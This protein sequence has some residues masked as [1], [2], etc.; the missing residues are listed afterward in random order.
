M[1]VFIFQMPHFSRTSPF[2]AW[3]KNIALD[4]A[5]VLYIGTVIL[6]IQNI[7]TTQSPIGVHVRL[8][9]IIPRRNLTLLTIFREN[10]F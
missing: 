1:E 5:V 6:D 10:P 8:H 2:S 3:T 9:I 4:L 7:I